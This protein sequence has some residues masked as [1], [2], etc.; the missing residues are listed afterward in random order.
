MIGS[1]PMHTRVARYPSNHLLQPFRRH[2]SFESV[3]LVRR[4]T[5]YRHFMVGGLELEMGV[6]V[7]SNII[8]DRC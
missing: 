5:G 6:I 2:K 4:S 7:R 1:C 3:G 8:G